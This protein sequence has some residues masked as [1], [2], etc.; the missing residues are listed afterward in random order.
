[1]A[2]ESGNTQSGSDGSY[3]YAVGSGFADKAVGHFTAC[4][5]PP[6]ATPNTDDCPTAGP[7]EGP[8]DVGAYTGSAS[9]YGTFDQGANV[10][11]WNEGIASGEL[12]GLRGG[13]FDGLGGLNASSA[14]SEDP[15]ITYADT[16][17][18]VARAVPE[19]AKTLLVLTGGLVLA[20][21]RQHRRA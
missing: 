20:A 6:A 16:G 2:Y 3:G 4:A 8:T 15:S 11:E 9:P 14:W 21:A 5:F 17:V 12:R 13:L 1:M 10:I 7:S 18:R 19:P